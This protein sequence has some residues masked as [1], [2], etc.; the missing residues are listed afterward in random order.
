[1]TTTTLEQDVVATAQAVADLLPTAA[2]LT[3]GQPIDLESATS[4]IAPDAVGAHAE[5]LGSTGGTVALVVDRSLAAALADSPMGPLPL[6]DALRPAL[7]T[8]R[9]ALGVGALGTV[10]EATA[11]GAVAALRGLQNSVGPLIGADG[12]AA[13]I[14]VGVAASNQVVAQPGAPRSAAPTSSGANGIELLQD[15]VMELS[16]ELGRTTMTVRDLLNLQPGAV[17]ELDRLAGSPADLLVNGRLVARGEVVVVDEDYALKIT[18]LVT[19]TL[20]EHD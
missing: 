6:V 13:W 20:A 2:P 18:E 16:A 10:A 15:V 4:A 5:V 3:A 7:E 17:V 14:A 11:A 1:M 8:L 12:S 9:S 19:G